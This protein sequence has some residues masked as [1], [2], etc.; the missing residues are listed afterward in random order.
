MKRPTRRFAQ[1]DGFVEGQET[2][3]SY[4]SCAAS[5]FI[6][7]FSRVTSP[8]SRL[9]ALHKKPGFRDLIIGISRT[10]P[11]SLTSLEAS[12]G[13]VLTGSDFL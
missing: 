4:E 9:I 6:A 12:D 2:F 11:R 10:Q 5:F 3:G 8:D 1:D 7:A 13:S